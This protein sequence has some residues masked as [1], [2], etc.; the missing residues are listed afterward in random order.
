VGVFV[1]WYPVKDEMADL[2]E[3]A[4]RRLCP[5]DQTDPFADVYTFKR[6]GLA[7]GLTETRVMVI[8]PPYPSHEA[9]K[10]CLSVLGE[11]LQIKTFAYSLPFG[12]RK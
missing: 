9:I 11:I 10:P 8:Q 1:I 5:K 6:S 7:K 12:S 4:I 3:D 2:F